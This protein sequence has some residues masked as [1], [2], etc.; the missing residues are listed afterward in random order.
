MQNIWNFAVSSPKKNDTLG[1][2]IILEV[3]ISIVQAS[4]GAK[5]EVPILDGKAS[6]KIPAGT[7]TGTTFKMKG[8]GMPYLHSYGSGDQLVIVTVKTPK[9][10]KRQEK[11][12]KELGKELGVE[13]EPERKWFEKFF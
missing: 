13:V 12:M 3:P 11:V 5:I 8:K 10:N 6:L 2:D 1:D 4:L 9:L 7:Q